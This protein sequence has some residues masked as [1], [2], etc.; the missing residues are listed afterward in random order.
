MVRAVSYGV[1]R[2]QEVAWWLYE[3]QV[4]HICCFIAPVDLST[5]VSESLHPR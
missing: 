4:M 2:L 3:R 5:H 1:K